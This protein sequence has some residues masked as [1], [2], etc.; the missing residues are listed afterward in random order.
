MLK[1]AHSPQPKISR[2]I[3]LSAIT[4]VIDI[5]EGTRVLM[6]FQN[7][8]AIELIAVD[9]LKRLNGK[10]RFHEMIFAV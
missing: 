6:F 4:K 7:E 9:C 8:C 10:D 3:I 2:Y 5:L 1:Y